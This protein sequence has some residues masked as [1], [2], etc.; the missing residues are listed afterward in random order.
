[1]L[2]GGGGGSAG[3]EDPGRGGPPATLL[4]MEVGIAGHLTLVCF[5]GKST[6]LGERDKEITGPLL[7]SKASG[8][9]RTKDLCYRHSFPGMPSLQQGG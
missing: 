5:S 7:P 4:R 2:E 6:P 3:Q 9:G 8:H 1:M